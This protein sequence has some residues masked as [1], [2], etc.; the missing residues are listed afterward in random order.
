[1]AISHISCLHVCE[2]IPWQSCRSKCRVYSDTTTGVFCYT[3]VALAG[4]LYTNST[5]LGEYLFLLSSRQ[6]SLLGLVVIEVS[7]LRR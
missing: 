2:V 4:L 3:F 1:M 6:S 5:V 7:E